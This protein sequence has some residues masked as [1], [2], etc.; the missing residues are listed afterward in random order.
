MMQLDGRFS[1]NA[2]GPL[3]GFGPVI[4]KHDFTGV[5]DGRVSGGS[6]TATENIVYDAPC[7]GKIARFTINGNR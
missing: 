3:P 7:P 1:G 5:L 4:L 6:I 2:S